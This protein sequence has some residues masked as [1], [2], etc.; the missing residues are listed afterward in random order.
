MCESQD[1]ETFKHRPLAEPDF[2]HDRHQQGLQVLGL[3]RKPDP[4]VFA[5]SHL[6]ARDA[7]AGPKG[8]VKVLLKRRH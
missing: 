1:L 5:S 4:V 7:A 6:D 3:L 2:L 8:V